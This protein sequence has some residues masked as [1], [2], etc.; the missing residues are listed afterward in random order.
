MATEPIST[1]FKVYDA[2][3]YTILGP[4]PVLELLIENDQ[5][6][7]AHEAGIF[8]A[9]RNELFVTSN[10]LMDAQ[11]QPMVRI[12]KVIFGDRS[13]PPTCED[14]QCDEI[15]MGNGGVN[16]KDDT[17]TLFCVQG[18]FDSPSG[19]CEMSTSPPYPSKLILSDFYGRP[20]NSTN[21][22]IVHRD[23]SI[24]FTDPIYGYEQG[25]RP[26][27]QLPNQVYRFDPQTR[28]VRV[29]ADGFERPNGICF[30]P[31]EMIVYVTDTG[32]VHGDGSIDGMRP[33]TI[34]AFDI[35]TYSGQPFLTNRRL[36]AMADSGIPDGIKCDI[37]GNVY[38]GCG[39][40]VNVWSPGGILLGKILVKDGVSNFCFGREG[41]MFLLNEQKLW[42]AQLSGFV[43]GALLK[44]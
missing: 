26:K 24:W 39:D 3:F 33:S 2:A 11:N 19:I 32:R 29:M 31:D 4:K 18:S 30:S 28:N 34:Y 44:I 42:R 23:G 16:Y 1:P 15:K 41:E 12:S 8:L 35:T 36:F 43:R 27:P 40:G 21:D 5:Y 37:D 9:S 22:V 38:S 7:F 25:Y 6:P 13:K 14:I 17:S 20:F 10:R